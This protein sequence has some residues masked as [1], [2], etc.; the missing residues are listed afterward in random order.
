MAAEI[1]LRLI[2]WVALMALLAATIGATFVPLGPWR[3][4]ISLTIAL[5]KAALVGG[6]FMELSKAPQMTRVVAL[7]TFAILT[8]LILMS[9]IDAAVRV[10]ALPLGQ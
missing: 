3:L 5:A 1:R 2:V 8:V 10:D 7:A 9:G 6:V 4:A